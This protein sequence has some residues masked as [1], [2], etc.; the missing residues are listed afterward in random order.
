M[1]VFLCQPHEFP[2]NHI[3][4]QV[5]EIP[6]DWIY[7][8]MGAFPKYVISGGERHMRLLE[9]AERMSGE[10]KH[11]NVPTTREKLRAKK[12]E[13]LSHIKGP[14]RAWSFET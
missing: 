7:V 2:M 4:V 10:I 3:F 14:E 6:E 8:G 1:P 12:K 13:N 11:E 5:K 9:K